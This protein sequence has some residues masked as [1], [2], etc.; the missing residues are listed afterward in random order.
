MLEKN[1]GATH[2]RRYLSF[3]RESYEVPRSRAAMPLLRA[4]NAF[5]GYRK[6][7]VAL[8]ALSRYIGR[9]NVNGAIRSMFAQHRSD[10]SS[11]PT[12]LDLYRELRAATPNSLHYL[13]R[14]LFETNTYWHLK[15]EQ[16]TAVPTAGGAW[17]VKLHVQ[18]RKV[19]VD[20]AGA[21]HEVPMNG[22][23]EIGVIAPYLLLMDLGLGDNVEEVVIKN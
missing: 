10:T 23:V 14:D 6:S 7:P 12:T 8:H 20:A 22:W 18:A 4:N 11:L 1:Y 16:A 17:Q 21:E 15:T 5:L 2:L 9:E 3:L 19:V 13:L